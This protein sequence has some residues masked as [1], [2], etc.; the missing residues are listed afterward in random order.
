MKKLFLALLSLTVFAGTGYCVNWWN[1]EQIDNQ[2]HIV[3]STIT[4]IGDGKRVYVG[5]GTVTLT[6]TCN[7]KDVVITSGNLTG[8]TNKVSVKFE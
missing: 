3:I 6:N 5:S 8:I 4:H 7:T 2:E 1:T